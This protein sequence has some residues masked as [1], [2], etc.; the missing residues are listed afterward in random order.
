MVRRSKM[1]RSILELVGR[2]ITDHRSSDGE[3]STDRRSVHR[4]LC[5]SAD[6]FAERLSASLCRESKTMNP[7]PTEITATVL[8]SLAVLHTFSV[9]RFAHWARKLPPGSIAE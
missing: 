2:G 1:P 4:K 9:K 8:F 5:H 3:S 7:T 6:R